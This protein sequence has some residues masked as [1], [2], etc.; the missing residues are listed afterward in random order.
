MKACLMSNS[1]NLLADPIYP[2]ATAGST[3]SAARSEG[4]TDAAKLSTIY[5]IDVGDSF[6][7][8]LV[9][10]DPD[11][12]DYVR[13]NLQA[14]IT[15]AFELKGAS[16][17]AGTLPDPVLRL[18]DAAG[19]AVAFNDDSG[20]GRDSRVVFTPTTS[21]PYYLDVQEYH[22]NAGSYL[23]T[24]GTTTPPPAGTLDE[25][26]T[27]LTT[28]YWA[29]IGAGS[30]KFNTSSS[31]QISV[32]LTSLT[33][34]GKDLAL[35][36]LAAW[37][38][39]ANLSFLVTTGSAK[40]TFLDTGS[41]ANTQSNY[42]NGYITTSTITIGAAWL[43]DFGASLDSY[44]FQSYIHEIGH[45]LG[46]GHQGNYNGAASFGT[47]NVFS[48]ESWQTSVMSYF[49]QTLN[50]SVD[51]S[52]AHLLTPMQ[53]DL[54]AIQRLYGAPG[55]SGATDGNTLWGITSIEGMDYL[56]L[57]ALYGPEA[58]I[59]L[60][61][62]EPV[63]L[64]IYDQGG[65]DTLDL[66]ASH[67]NDRITLASE[68][69]SDLYGLI[70][71]LAIARGTVVEDLL[72]G[73]GND[74]VAGNAAAN[75]IHLNA[76]N[77]LLNADV[78]N[79]LGYGG[80]G[81][82]TL[83]GGI[84]FDTLYG[85]EG[86]DRLNGEAHADLLYGGL[87]NDLLIGGDGFD[88][89]YGGED[90]DT[91]W[92]DATADRLSGEAGNDV[93]HGG[94]NFGTSVDGLSG[95]DGDDTLFGDAG[96]DLLRG[97]AGNDMLYGGEQADN[98]YG[99]TGEDYLS[100]GNGFDR[101]FGGEA[102]DT[103][104]GDGGTDALFGNQGDDVL[105]GGSEN[106]RLWGDSGNDSLYGGEGSDSLNGG[107]GFDVLEGGAGN[108]TLAG[109]F[110]ADTFIFR[111]GHGVDVIRDFDANSALEK[112]DFSG[113]STL[114]SLNDVL[115]HAVQQAQDVLITTSADS[116]ILLK[117]IELADLDASDFLF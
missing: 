53:A 82:D 30:Y 81:A 94:S 27:Y 114:N 92:G 31:N 24:T 96:F 3:L 110:N 29:D 72:T 89:L 71:N 104:N 116:S 47:D 60:A 52:Y 12:S 5:T 4:S 42:V 66:S 63:A 49:A 39:V 99:G 77:D 88:N 37:A 18:V 87:G 74:I 35:A 45:A 13:I 79:D 56:D 90:N 75:I 36:A 69:F 98:L 85:D 25:M 84:G 100:G 78:G 21:G 64:T 34:E 22:G 6:R 48:N 86:D 1:D 105:Y 109:A 32:N 26:A 17:S 28:G 91:L 95:G 113:L 23:L 76:G 67:S 73:S 58:L 55:A 106:D 14:G 7:G 41:D 65:H 10:N 112:I 46:L 115:A 61:S 111:D 70:G 2:D 107:A 80:A 59:P 103:L 101:L 19:E 97:D 11:A 20:S 68:G 50:P 8:T 40:I 43:S 62:S 117:F 83:N 9:S 108:D 57:T 51:A 16:S 93:L 54:I 33:I 15:Y 102:N 38:T 44:S